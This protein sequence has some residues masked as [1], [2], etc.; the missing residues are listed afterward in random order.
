VG[1]GAARACAHS[2]RAELSRALA[3][4]VRGTR[5]RAR[6][7]PRRTRAGVAL[8]P[9]SRPRG[10]AAAEKD[11]PFSNPIL[12]QVGQ[13]TPGWAS[14]PALS[15]AGR[16]G[17]AAHR[18]VHRPTVGFT[19][20]PAAKKPSG[21]GLPDRTRTVSNSARAELAHAPTPL[22]A[23][24]TTPLHLHAPQLATPR[25]PATPHALTPSRPHTATPAGTRA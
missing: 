19:E 3:V 22:L 15:S 12:R 17:P 10:R 4:A 1:V 25:A 14:G 6:A 18:G 8:A 11:V 13:R 2:A 21:P 7:R 20:P 16:S 23:R 24:P 9:A 5:T